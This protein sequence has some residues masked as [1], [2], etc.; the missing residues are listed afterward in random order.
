MTTART[1]VPPATLLEESNHLAHFH[2]IKPRPAPYNVRVE[3]SA[4]S[5][6]RIEADLSRPCTSLLPHRSRQPRSRSNALL[7]DGHP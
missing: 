7:D 3:R 5:V 2:V 6:S 4:A 1:D